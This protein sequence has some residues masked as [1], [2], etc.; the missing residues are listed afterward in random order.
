MLRRRIEFK[1]AEKFRVASKQ[2]IVDKVCCRVCQVRYFAGGCARYMFSYPTV[3]VLE[4]I[5]E[6]ISI[7]DDV[8]PHQFLDKLVSSQC[9]LL[10]TCFVLSGVK[11]EKVLRRP[12]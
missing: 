11:R 12:V 6:S 1:Y 4:N 8:Y 9:Q 3:D 7:C 2:E 10:M 5:E